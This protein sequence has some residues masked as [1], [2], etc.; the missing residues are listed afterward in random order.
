MTEHAGVFSLLTAPVYAG[1]LF[2]PFP[3]HVFAFDSATY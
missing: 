3:L 2:F 1:I